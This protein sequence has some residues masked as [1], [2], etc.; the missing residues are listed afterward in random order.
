MSLNIVFSKLTGTPGESGWSQVHEYIPQE[1]E[2][3][4]VRGRLVA[5]FAT[6]KSEQGLED[7]ALG[8]E[9]LSRLHEEYFG[10]L[11]K[12]AFNCLRD[13]VKKTTDEFQE[14]AAAVFVDNA[15]Y[16]AAASGGQVVIYRNGMLAKIIESK[17]REV[18]SASGYPKEGD[19]MVLG[20]RAFFSE[21][22]G[23]TLKAALEKD[24]PLTSTELL[25]PMAHSSSL[26]DRIACVVVKF[27]KEKMASGIVDF[28]Q[29]KYTLELGE[30]MCLSKVVK[31]RHF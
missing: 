25:A 26:T 31:S 29:K 22:V 23:G 9:C 1:E 21:I 10:N 4:N 28:L 8:R 14:I 6:G 7:V 5:V 18:V 15:V 19:S 30:K 27:E 11:E 12:S 13:S 2:K 3:K 20:T 24:L 17:R 16:T